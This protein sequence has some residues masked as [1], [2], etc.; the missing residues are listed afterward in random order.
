MVNDKGEKAVESEN[1]VLSIA[2][3]AMEDLQ[4]KAQARID[5]SAIALSQNK[6]SQR[7]A[8]LNALKESN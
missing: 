5:A 8:E 7:E 1:G 2:D 4:K 6:Q 3:W